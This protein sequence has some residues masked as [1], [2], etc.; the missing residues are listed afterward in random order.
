MQYTLATKLT[1]SETGDKSATKSTVAD[2]VNFVADTVDFVAV[3]TGPKQH[4]RLCGLSIKSTVLNSTSSAECTG[5]YPSYGGMAC[6]IVFCFYLYFSSGDGYLGVGASNWRE[7]LRDDKA[8]YTGHVF[9][10]FGGDI[11][12]VS[13]FGVKKRF[14][15]DDFWSLGHRF[16]T[17]DREFLENGKSQGQ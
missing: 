6:Y 16:F 3:C 4:G 9:S 11:F 14:R 7:L 5:L 12:G 17:L 2:A 10:R 8:T 1:V 13:K 15:V